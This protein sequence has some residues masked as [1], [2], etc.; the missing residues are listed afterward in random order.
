MVIAFI[1][2][3]RLMFSGAATLHSRG[4]NALKWN[5]EH[6]TDQKEAG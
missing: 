1:G 5:S 4:R 3:H 2:R 6:Q